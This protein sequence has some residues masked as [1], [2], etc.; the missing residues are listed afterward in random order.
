[1]QREYDEMMQ[2]LLASTLI[3]IKVIA[4]LIIWFI[5]TIG[6]NQAAEP[7]LT[8]W[9]VFNA[10][11]VALLIFRSQSLIERYQ[12]MQ[13]FENFYEYLDYLKIKPKED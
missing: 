4:G 1:M 6:F 3:L 2:R 5:I 11:V 8:A 7:G 10:V 9:N 13:T 12:H